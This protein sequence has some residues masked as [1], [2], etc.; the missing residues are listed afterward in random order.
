MDYLGQK[1][2]GTNRIE[3]HGE[4]KTR[5]VN[6]IIDGGGSVVATGSKGFVVIDFAC[7]IVA[8]TIA[9]DQSGSAVVDVKRATYSGFPTT[10]SIAGTAKPTLSSVQKNQNTTL[11]GWGNTAIAAGDVLEF[12]VDSATTVTKLLVSL[13]VTVS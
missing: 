11:T 13:K 3:T 4:D 6:F 10:A 5:T 1:G 9:A 8:W 2:T 7:S 12:N